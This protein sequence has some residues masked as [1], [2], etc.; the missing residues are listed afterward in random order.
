MGRYDRNKFGRSVP[1]GWDNVPKISS[2]A[3]LMAQRR[4]DKIPDSTFD[5]DGDG[6]VSKEDYTISLRND[7]NKDGRLDTA[8]RKTALAEVEAGRP[9]AKFDQLRPITAPHLVRSDSTGWPQRNLPTEEPPTRSKLLETRRKE[10]VTKNHKGYLKYEE[11]VAKVQPAWK[12]SEEYQL[13]QSKAAET[14]PPQ[15]IR[16]VEQEALKQSKRLHA[17]LTATMHTLNPDRVALDPVAHVSGCA[18]YEDPKSAA[19]LGYR[20]APKY[21]TRSSLQNDRRTTRLDQL[22]ESVR[23]VAPT[24]KNMRMRLEERENAEFLKAKIALSDPNNR[25]RSDLTRTRPPQVWAPPWRSRVPARGPS[26][27]DR[28]FFVEW[29]R[30]ADA[31]VPLGGVWERN[32]SSRPSSAGGLRTG[33]LESAREG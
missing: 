6:C 25:V 22:E 16:S 18:W 23:R 32:A 30:S 17:G 33:G 7:K 27:R 4:R 13:C 15:K 24:F 21:P 9:Q 1:R 12:K 19:L 29:V 8:E 28:L 11:A 31:G 26:A 14:Q 2:R 20:D 3:E 10:L 5:L